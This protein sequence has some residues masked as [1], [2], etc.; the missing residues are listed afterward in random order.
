VRH[1][2]HGYKLGR[3]TSHRLAL[4]RNLVRSLFLH[5]RI[6]TTPQKARSALPLAEKLVQIAKDGLARG[7]KAILERRLAKKLL[8][9]DDAVTA[10]FTTVAPA[11]T[12]RRGGYTRVLRL[13]GLR[14]G[15]GAER[16]LWEIV[17]LGGKTA[18]DRAERR[19]KRLAT[20]EAKEKARQEKRAAMAGAG[21]AG[22]AGGG[23]S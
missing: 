22:G 6:E 11:L 23:G 18:R 8:P 14:V 21:G 2:K 7:D 4:R 3:T 15:D 16:C 9:N 19:E 5:H 13:A 10:L 17:G 1:R 20:I 12:D